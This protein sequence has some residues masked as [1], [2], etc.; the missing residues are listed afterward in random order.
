MKRVI[1]QYGCVS[2]RI[3]SK[4]IV[5]YGNR[6]E[7][8]WSGEDFEDC[9]DVLFLPEKLNYSVFF[10]ASEK[11]PV[12]VSM[13]YSKPDIVEDVKALVVYDVRKFN[14]C[15][16]NNAEIFARDVVALDY[17]PKAKEL[18]KKQR[19]EIGPEYVVDVNDIYNDLLNLCV[20]VCEGYS[21]TIE[22]VILGPEIENLMKKNNI[23]YSISENFT[24]IHDSFNHIFIDIRGVD[25]FEVSEEYVMIV[26]GVYEGGKEL[27]HASYLG[28]ESPDTTFFKT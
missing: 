6:I 7:A 22:A 1:P 15:V 19:I 2:H 21:K 12:V 24:Y 16:F 3:T 10:A 5:V 4:D 8:R 13:L 17:I 26:Y 18:F 11:L 20:K 25:P 23:T 27:A 9:N 28:E 14:E